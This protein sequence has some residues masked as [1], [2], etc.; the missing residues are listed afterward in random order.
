MRSAPAPAAAGA[1]R[2]P[3]ATFHPAWSG[4]GAR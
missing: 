1:G 3:G 4:N 2:G